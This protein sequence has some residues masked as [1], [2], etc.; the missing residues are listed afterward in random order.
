MRSYRV[1]ISNIEDLELATGGNREFR[2]TPIGPRQV[3]GREV[4]PRKA[5]TPD[6]RA[7]GSS[8]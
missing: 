6:D 4:E 2:P 7:A 8:V 5:Q 1:A 3:T